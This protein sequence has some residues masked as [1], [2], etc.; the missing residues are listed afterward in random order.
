MMVMM[1]IN[2][3]FFVYLTLEEMQLG[4][5]LIFVPCGDSFAV[6]LWWNVSSFCLTIFW[7]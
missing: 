2:L 7:I 4:R 1:H 5:M 6:L 3:Y